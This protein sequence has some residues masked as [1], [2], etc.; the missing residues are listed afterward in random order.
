LNITAG[1]EAS[2]SIV[3]DNRER[4]HKIKNFALIIDSDQYVSLQ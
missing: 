2:F 3:M 1:N 4:S